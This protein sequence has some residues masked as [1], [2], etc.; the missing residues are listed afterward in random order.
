MVPVP[1]PLFVLQAVKAKE[2]IKIANRDKNLNFVIMYCIIVLWLF[3]VHV[4]EQHAVLYVP[5]LRK[6]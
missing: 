6:F 4:L 5:T 1:G 3:K 2:V